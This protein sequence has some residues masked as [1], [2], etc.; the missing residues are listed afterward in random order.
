MIEGLLI[1]LLC[2]LAGTLVADTLHLPIP[3]AVLGMLL[4]LGLLAWRR[5][6]EDAPVMTAS[7]HLLQHLPLLFVPAG[8][9]VVAVLGLI[10]EHR[11]LMLVGFVVPWL[12]GLVVTAGVA[13][14]LAFAA[15]CDRRRSLSIRAAAKPGL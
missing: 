1:L 3:G 6:A 10:G 11:A 4:L 2:Q 12:L 7:H 5:P 8:V 15:S 14:P 9:G 13:A